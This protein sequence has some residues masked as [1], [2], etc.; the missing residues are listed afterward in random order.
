MFNTLSCALKLGNKLPKVL[1]SR[2][3]LGKVE[4]LIVVDT[5]TQKRKSHYFK[6]NIFFVLFEI[7]LQNIIIY[8]YIIIPLTYTMYHN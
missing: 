6:T 2:R 1:I 5:N 7:F 4:R 3:S 8:V